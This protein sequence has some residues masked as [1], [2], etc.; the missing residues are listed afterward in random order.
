MELDIQGIIVELQTEDLAL[1][2]KDVEFIE[3]EEDIRVKAKKNRKRREEIAILIK[4]Y[5]K[6]ITPQ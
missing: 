2:V 3:K 4:A 1:E 5:Q 6:L